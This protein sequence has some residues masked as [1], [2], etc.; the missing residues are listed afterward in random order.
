MYPLDHPTRY[1]NVIH[2]ETNRNIRWL[3]IDFSNVF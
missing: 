1:P 2:S 3:D